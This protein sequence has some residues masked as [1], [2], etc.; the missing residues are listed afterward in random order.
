MADALRADIE[1]RPDAFRPHSLARMGSQSQASIL[2]FLK[3]LAEGLG[4]GTP[5][6]SANSDA[7]DAGGVTP[8]FRC[9]AKDAGRLFRPEV[10]DRVEDPVKGDPELALSAHPRCFHPIKKRFELDA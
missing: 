4:A 6:I 8:Q 7:H 5:L 10:T 3:E 2:G 1:R 9:F